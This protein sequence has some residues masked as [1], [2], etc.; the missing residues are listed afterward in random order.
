MLHRK[1][2]KWRIYTITFFKVFCGDGG[3]YMAIVSVDI[4]VAVEEAPVA[5]GA[6]HEAVKTGD[7]D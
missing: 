7:E 5:T 4:M 2:M 1:K 3:R 6:T